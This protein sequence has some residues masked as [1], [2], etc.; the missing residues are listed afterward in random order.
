M[1]V[2]LEEVPVNEVDHAGVPMTEDLRQHPGVGAFGDE[3]GGSRVTEVVRRQGSE[4]CPNSRRV[5]VAP[6]PVAGTDE[7]TVSPGKQQA[8][9]FVPPDVLIDVLLQLLEGKVGHRD[10]TAASCCLGALK[11]EMS[12]DVGQSLVDP[13]IALVPV[14]VVEP[15]RAKL[16]DTE[17]AVGGNVDH[18]LVA[19]CNFESEMLN[20]PLDDETYRLVLLPGDRRVLWAGEPCDPVI[21]QGSPHDL[22]ERLVDLLDGAGSKG[23][24]SHAL[25]LAGQLDHPAFDVGLGDLGEGHSPPLGQDVGVEVRNVAGV[26]GSSQAL[27]SEGEVVLGPVSERDLAGGIVDVGAVLDGVLLVCEKPPRIALALEALALALAIRVTPACPKF[28]L[29]E[30]LDRSHAAPS[31][32]SPRLTVPGGVTRAVHDGQKMGRQWVEPVAMPASI[33]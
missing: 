17:A 27:A 13:D 23:A 1:A 33:G 19:R 3:E 5:E 18:G 8:T 6:P 29:A 32:D 15:E 4:T 2:L 25:V 20:F 31:D 26:A 9:R 16:T 11:L 10:D 21:L 30:L 28:A 7:P 14:D 12:V 22:A 24:A